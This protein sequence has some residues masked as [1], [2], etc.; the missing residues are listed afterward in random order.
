MLVSDDWIFEGEIYNVVSTY[1]DESDDHNYYFLAERQ[2]RVPTPM[3]RENRFVPL[4]GLAAPA[5]N[6]SEQVPEKES[7]TG[8]M[9]HQ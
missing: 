8:L 7:T 5:R 9:R 1:Y 3:Y 4:S 6:Y 2:H